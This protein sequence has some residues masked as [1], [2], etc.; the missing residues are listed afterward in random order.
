M[1][2]GSHYVERTPFSQ[3]AGIAECVW[4]QEVASGGEAHNQRVLPDGCVDMLWRD[5]VLC[6]AGPDTRWRVESIP[7]GTS[8]VGIRLRPGA[9]R[10]LFGNM[11]ASDARNQQLD[12]ADVWGARHTRQLVGQ[13]A[14]ARSL[15][16]VAELLEAAVLARL[17]HT[18]G[19]DPLVT[20][21]VAVLDNPRPEPVWAVAERLG[22]SERQLRRRFDSSVGYGPKVLEGVLR[23]RR[24]IRL[25]HS[26]PYSDRVWA[27]DVAIEAGYS[28]QPHMTREMR[29]LAGV[30][31]G[32]LIPRRRHPR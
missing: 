8:I 27:A 3:L 28:D 13:A 19:L 21:A 7:M 6:V 16:Q 29:R 22:L 18:G 4:F 17:P 1:M 5:G 31:P 23:L 30:T 10:V 12:L 15:P 20:A 26:T 24:A 11:P 32:E 14:E 2:T 25:A 9:A